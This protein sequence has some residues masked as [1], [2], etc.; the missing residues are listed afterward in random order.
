[1]FDGAVLPELSLKNGEIVSD[2]YLLPDEFGS[3]YVELI[4]FSQSMT[5]FIFNCHWQK[6]RSFKLKS[7]GRIR[8][9]F[10]LDFGMK[11]ELDEDESIST[12]APTL[13]IVKRP[14]G[15]LLLEKI[16]SDA[17]TAWVTI[18]VTREYLTGLFG[19]Q[20]IPQNSELAKLLSGDSKEMLFEQF[21]IDH[22][23]NLILSHLLSKNSHENLH[24]SYVNAKILELTCIA[25]ERI[26]QVEPKNELPVK[27]NSR[28]ERAV[29]IVR[30]IVSK[31]LA[32]VPSVREIC[33]MVG[34]NRNKLHY[35]FKHFYNVSLS[36]FIKEERLSRSY[37]LLEETEKTVIEIAL[38]VGF[39][40][41]SSLSTAFKKKYGISPIQLRKNLQNR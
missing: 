3:G 35:G 32:D 38:E 21:S 29:K 23:I 5:V 8:F 28:D 10:S 22:N 12:S 19:E 25:L 11:T 27:L 17:Q 33:L 34:M 15:D 41:Q 31:N 4:K 37:G 1:M 2:L 20:A 9:N 14:K 16:Q 30:E 40:H 13:R 24:L 26:I 18:V 36:Q 39:Q 6:A 7:D